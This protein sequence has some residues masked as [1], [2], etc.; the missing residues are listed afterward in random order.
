MSDV[1]STIT[2]EILNNIPWLKVVTGGLA[3]YQKRRAVRARD[4]LL[5]ELRSAQISN[6]EAMN[7]DETIA[8]I[9][10]YGI[11]VRDGARDE[12]LLILAKLMKGQYEAGNFDDDLYDRFARAFSDLSRDELKLGAEFLKLMN[13]DSGPHENQD[14][15]VKIWMRLSE[16]CIPKIFTDSRHLGATAGAMHS[17][18]LLEIISG[19]GGMFYIPTP[20][21]WEARKLMRAALDP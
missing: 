3:A 5:S 16:N 21:L 12:N 19:Y 6:V 10:R 1:P 11:A 2:D 13:F 7:R 17:K 9:Y 8:I 18:G 4:I 20:L 14:S 15:L